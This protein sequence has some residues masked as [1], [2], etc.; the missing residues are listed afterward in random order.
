MTTNNVDYKQFVNKIIELLLNS[1][2]NE[3]FDETCNKI[4]Q[5]IYNIDGCRGLYKVINMVEDELLI[6]EY[7][8][9]HLDSLK[10][11]ELSFNDISKELY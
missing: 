8:N 10:Q 6:C 11:I 2:N 5:E 3:Y 9:E 7:S 4:G 1:S